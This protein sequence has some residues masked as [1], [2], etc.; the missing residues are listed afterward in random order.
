M[1]L[2]RD[3]RVG[4]TELREAFLRSQLPA[5]RVASEVG[6]LRR[7]NGL[8]CGDGTRLNRA[9]GIKAYKGGKGY[10]HRLHTVDYGLAVRLADVLGL[11][12]VEAGF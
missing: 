10:T 12:P 4:N 8:T 2:F 7:C 1:T 6:L 11:D 9:L 3:G 5:K